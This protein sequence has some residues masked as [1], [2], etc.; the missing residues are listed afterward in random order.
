MELKDLTIQLGDLNITNIRWKSRSIEISTDGGK[1]Y[2]RPTYYETI[3]LYTANLC[4]C[5]GSGSGGG[6]SVDVDE[7]KKE[8]EEYILKKY[9]Q[10]DVETLKTSITSDEDFKKE[11]ASLVEVDSADV[12]TDAIATKVK[13]DIKSDDEFKS[14]VAALVET[15]EVDTDKIVSTV[16]TNLKADDDFKS[17]IAKS[18]TVDTDTITS[19]VETN[20][21]ADESF[22]KE[23]AA[24]VDVDNADVDT[25][26]IET[27]VKTA[28]KSDDEFKSAVAALVDTSDIS[29]TVETNVKADDTFKSEVAKLV[30]VDTDSI[31]TNIKAD[32]TFKKSVAALVETSGSDID[33][34][35][36]E[37]NVK[38]SIK[39]DS[40]F[41]SEI[42]TTVKTNIKSDETFKSE[43]VKEVGSI[44]VDTDA[45]AAIVE[46]NVKED[47]TFKSE[48]VSSTETNIKSDTDFKTAV[49][50]L[51][52]TSD[53]ETNI[54]EDTDFKSE[55]S[56]TIETALKDDETF[57][58]AVAESIDTDTI[59]S[60]IETNVK[61]DSD[62]KAAVAAL[63]DIDKSFLTENG[64]GNLRYYNNN[65]SYYNGSEWIDIVIT[66]NNQFIINMTPANMPS[67]GTYIERDDKCISLIWEEP[68]DTIIDSQVL[69][70]VEGIKIVRKLG[71]EPESVSDGDLI[72]DLKRADFGKHNLVSTAYMDKTV[73]FTAGNI[74]Y[75]KFFPY[76]SNG[77][78]TNST[79]NCKSITITDYTLFGFVL[80]Q[81]ESD[82]DSMIT[83]IEEN[84]DYKSAYMDFD[85]NTFNYGSWEGAWFIRKLKPCMLKL[86][87]T[88][89][90]ELD[91]NDYTKK[92]NG[93]DSDIAN[94]DYEGNVMIGIPKVYWKIVDNE[95]DTC[96]VYICDT[97]LDDD[98][99]CWSHIDANGNEINYCYMS[100]YDCKYNSTSTRLQS[101]SG[102][103][104]TTKYSSTM[105]KTYA[106]ANNV[107]ESVHIWDNSTF[108]DYTL[109]TLL[110]LLIIKSTDSQSKIGGGNSRN[111]SV[112][113][114]ISGKCNNYGLFFGTNVVGSADVYPIKLFGIENFWGNMGKIITGIMLYQS[115][116]YIKMTYGTQDGS[117][118]AGYDFGGDNYIGVGN[119]AV[120]GTSGG[121]VSK[122]AFTKYGLLPINMNGSSSTYFTDATYFDS[123]SNYVI[124]GGRGSLG[125][126]NGLFCF[127]CNNS[128][129]TNS[130]IGAGLSCKPLAPVSSS[131][132]TNET[133]DSVAEDS[134]TEE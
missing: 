71:S 86:D 44:V 87:G 123:T 124:I 69:C 108:C 117:S 7:L 91:K 133:T 125:Y 111:T 49:A 84:R 13:T 62:F 119:A 78:V 102:V 35:E 105:I 129:L 6:S 130:L 67:F 82:P 64:F 38:T 25:D 1:S 90:Y 15:S 24:L 134:V 112:T 103:A 121:Y 36:I 110:T 45:I 41:K 63:I 59:I 100:V 51:V 106:E 61:G 18:V 101:V 122:L 17:E 28:I 72:L 85:T 132:S 98:F 75:Y 70:Y 81:T 10:I 93:A 47:E 76:A 5:D 114:S 92:I 40:E 99:H 66:S 94:E 19:T 107:D 73:D 52:D 8:I 65:F 27:N 97:K 50:A 95:D 104:P 113:L 30:E 88:V 34:S 96:N 116:Y 79:L 55:I 32:E 39:E 3:N 118:S 31:E 60:T 83:Y 128:F 16:Q 46:T 29:S 9:P 11:V 33:T 58:T 120:S 77:L 56:S 4:D 109:I 115:E 23:V 43:I 80:D 42:A 12:D 20:V 131:D 68:D 57:K 54:K 22:K 21:K 74:Y 14:E 126:Q 2:R 53:V 26:A 89:D 127:T 48:I 37:T